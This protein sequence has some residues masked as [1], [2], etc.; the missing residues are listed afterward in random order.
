LPREP[1]DVALGDVALGVG[2]ETCCLGPIEFDIAHAS[3]DGSGTPIEV[4]ALY[5][6]ADQSL[7][8]EC[9]ILKLAMATAWRWSRATISRTAAP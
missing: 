8:R 5:D 7:G 9:R 6:G 4:G 3:V 2:G 1:V